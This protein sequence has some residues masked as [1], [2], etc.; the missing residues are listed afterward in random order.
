MKIKGIV[1]AISVLVLSSCSHIQKTNMAIWG[2][3][4]D[5]N[6]AFVALGKSTYE[7][8]CVACHGVN[9]LGNGSELKA[10]MATPPNFTDGTYDKSLG[11]VAANIKYGKRIDMPAFRDKLSDEQIWAVANYVK[12]L[13]QQL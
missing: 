13:H 1:A 5:V 10:N 3:P 12:S 8:Q 6:D 4:Y 9:G 7:Q 2:N 11:L